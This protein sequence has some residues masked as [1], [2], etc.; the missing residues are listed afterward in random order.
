[1]SGGA[2]PVTPQVQAGGR[3]A[4]PGLLH[5]RRPWRATSCVSTSSPCPPGRL[6]G[7]RSSREGGALQIATL[8]NVGLRAGSPGD[9]AGRRGAHRCPAGR[10]AGVAG[11]P[12]RAGA[13]QRPHRHGGGPGRDHRRHP[14]PLTRWPR[15]A[16]APAPHLQPAARGPRVLPARPESS[17]S[18]MPPTSC[19]PRSPACAPISR[20]SA[21]ST[22][23][24]RPIAR[25]WSTMS[26]SSCRS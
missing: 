8:L 17:S 16:R 2:L 25:C 18:S 9:R 15:R 4:G 14:S 20:S 21:G 6:S 3:R 10:R 11:G 7:P 24:P 1:M 5:H 13:P 22:S 19:A 23:S 12:D 26:W